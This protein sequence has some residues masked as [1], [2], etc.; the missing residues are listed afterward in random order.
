MTENEHQLLYD[1]L[2]RID[3]RTAKHSRALARVEERLD[4]V[5]TKEDCE[6]VRRKKAENETPKNGNALIQILSNKRKIFIP[7]GAI[8]AAAAAAVVTILQA[9]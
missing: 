4:H 7:A 8:L 3:D 6:A 1:M 2:S 5:V 9:L